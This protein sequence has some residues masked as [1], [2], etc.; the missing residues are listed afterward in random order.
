[1]LR[2]SITLQAKNGRSDSDAL[3]FVGPL[4]HSRMHNPIKKINFFLDKAYLIEYY[5]DGE[6][7]YLNASRT[8]QIF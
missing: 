1:M 6:V 2:P 4:L 8:A 3:R 5:L 7:K